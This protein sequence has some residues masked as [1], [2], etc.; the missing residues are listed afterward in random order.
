MHALIQ[1]DAESAKLLMTALI[2]RRKE[3]VAHS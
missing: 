1:T 2:Y 3:L